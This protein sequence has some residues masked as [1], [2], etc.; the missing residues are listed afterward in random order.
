MVQT[1][2]SWSP[3]DLGERPSGPG[4]LSGPGVSG[5]VPALQRKVP[6]APASSLD[7]VTPGNLRRDTL[8]P[9]PDQAD[10]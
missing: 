7:E 10:G 9:P 1:A 8:I 5:P 4:A 3:A 6:A 2:S